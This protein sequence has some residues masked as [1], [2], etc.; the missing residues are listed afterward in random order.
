MEDEQKKKQKRSD[1]KDE[2]MESV[3]LNKVEWGDFLEKHN[4]ESDLQEAENDLRDA[5]Q[6]FD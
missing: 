1:I 6:M 5:F 2:C 3:S 4:V